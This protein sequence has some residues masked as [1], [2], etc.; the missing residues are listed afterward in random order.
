MATVKKSKRAPKP[1]AEKKEF[2]KAYNEKDENSGVVETMLKMK[3]VKEKKD[4][5]K[6]SA[7]RKRTNRLRR[8]AMAEEIK[9]KY[10]GG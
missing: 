2:S 1:K 7:A 3:E 6:M 9:K 4:K 8:A 10:Y 5:P